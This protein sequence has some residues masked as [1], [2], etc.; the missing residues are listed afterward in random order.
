MGARSETTVKA[1]SLGLLFVAASV[2]IGVISA[3]PSCNGLP[4]KTC[5]AERV[6]GLGVTE[7]SGPSRACTSCLQSKG[8]PH[9]CCD[10]VGAC[11]EDPEKK[12][13][14][15]FKTAHLCVLDGDGGASKESEC[16]SHLTGERSRTLYTCMRSNCAEE[17]GGIPSCDLASEVALFGSS[18]CDTCVSN[19]CC[20]RR[21]ECQQNRQCR[22]VVECISNHCPRTLGSSMT[23]LGLLSADARREAKEAVCSGKPLPDGD[24]STACIQ[25][26]L[27]EF[28]RGTPDDQTARCLAFG[29]FACGAEASCGSKCVDAGASS[30]QGVWPE[31]DPER[32]KDGGLHDAGAD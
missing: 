12:C 26:C 16:R 1:R 9:A 3:L 7:D 8:A 15:E 24:A 31:D 5:F 28:D 17:C 25:R 18:E 6:N 4:N 23:T 13:V 19:S 29:V 30:D 27:D 20:E 21:N 32:M 14:D 22:F 11:D 10:A 2:A